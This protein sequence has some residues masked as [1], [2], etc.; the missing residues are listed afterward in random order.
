MDNKLFPDLANAEQIDPTYY[1]DFVSNGVKLR[2]NASMSN[3]SGINFIYMAFA[4][5]PFKY[6]VGR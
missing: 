2:S 1:I 6:S 5:M 4:E 3:Q